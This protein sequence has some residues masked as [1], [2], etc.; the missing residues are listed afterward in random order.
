MKRLLVRIAVTFIV[1]TVSTFAQVNI[2]DYPYVVLGSG[3]GTGRTNSHQTYNRTL[4]SDTVYYISGTY[5]V[6]STYSLTIQPGTIIKGDTSATLVIMRGAK[7]FANGTAARPVVFTSGKPVGARAPG[8]WGGVVI[9]GAAPINR[10]NPTIEG[11]FIP[12]TYGGADPNDNSGVFKYCRIEFPGYRFQTNNEINGLTMCGVGRG[13]EIHHVQVSYSNDDSFEFFGGTVDV[14]HLIAIGGVDDEFDTDFGYQ[15]RGQ[16]LFAMKDPNRW[17]PTGQSNGFESDNW[18]PGLDYAAPRTSYRFS[19]VTLIGPHRVDTVANR[20]GNTFQYA[21]LLRRGTNASFYNSVI[22][23]YPGGLALRDLNTWEAAQH[24]SLQIRN[25]NIFAWD[26]TTSLK[27]INTNGTIDTNLIHAWY[28]TAAWANGGLD[29]IN[30]TSAALFQG[31]DDITNPDPRP[32][33]GSV[34]ATAGTKYFWITNA[35][36][37]GGVAFAFDSVSYRGA[38]DPTQP[39][40]AQWSAGWTNFNPH[41]TQYTNLNNGWNL[42]S[43]PVTT[44]SYAASTLYPDASGSIFAYNGASYAPSTTLANGPGY[45]AFYTSQLSNK[46]FG[47]Y[48]AGTTVTASAA[49]WVLVGSTSIPV[50]TASVTTIPSGQISGSF[51]GYNGITYVPQTVLNPGK[52]YWVYVTGACT[53]TLP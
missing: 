3:M 18:D 33:T 24:D 40:S 53:I 27:L 25:T 15:G 43:V 10:V 5:C 9:C 4:S 28:N 38:F 47:Q 36:V 50:T 7:I 26:G 41:N 1:A 46:M 37:S 39:M 44:P 31:L 22:T 14:H 16:Y 13:T 29:G 8:D 17:D 21:A 42:V 2:H 48:F 32:Q 35:S 23:G 20:A 51:Y 12:G 49:G 11:G 45:W 19:N 6:D 52:A 30:G 34:L